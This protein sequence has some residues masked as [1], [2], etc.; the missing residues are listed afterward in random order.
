MSNVIK[1]TVAAVAELAEIQHSTFATTDVVIP[2]GTNDVFNC[3]FT[4]SPNPNNQFLK[5]GFENCKY[6][7]LQFRLFNSTGV[8]F[9]DQTIQNTS[10]SYQIPTNTLPSG[11]YI[12]QLQSGVKSISKKVMVSH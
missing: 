7:N 6:D 12:L 10:S 5:I 9:Y 11:I 8:L 2:V 1:A 3:N 4:V